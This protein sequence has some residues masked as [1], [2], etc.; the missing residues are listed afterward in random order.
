MR[1]VLTM[2]LAPHDSH[3]AHVQFAL[4]RRVPAV[5]G[6]LGTMKLPFPSRSFDMAHC[7]HCLVPWT[8]N[9]K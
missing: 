1:N 4:E 3:E 5:I 7:S 9:G 6:V 8:S 2:S